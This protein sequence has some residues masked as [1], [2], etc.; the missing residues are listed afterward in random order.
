ME[1]AYCEVW[2]KPLKDVAEHEHE[3]CWGIGDDCTSCDCLSECS[4][5]EE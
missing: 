4:S 5:D 2:C 1:E 3:S